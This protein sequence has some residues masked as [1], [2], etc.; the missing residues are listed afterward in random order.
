MKDM[1]WFNFILGL[2][3]IFL[4][5][6]LIIIHYHTPKQRKI[7]FKPRIKLNHNRYKGSVIID[8]EQATEK[9]DYKCGKSFYLDP[10]LRLPKCWLS[11]KIP[12]NYNFPNTIIYYATLISD[13]SWILIE[14]IDW[15]NTDCC[16]FG[17]NLQ[18]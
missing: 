17:V 15:C 4:C 3:F 11:E 12:Q 8:P 9:A 6:K 16:L 13:H 14:D 2:N 7:K 5:F 18:K 10:I 1:L